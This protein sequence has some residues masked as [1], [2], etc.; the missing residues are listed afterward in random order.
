MKKSE[1]Q[2]STSK[3]SGEDDEA[4]KNERLKRLHQLR[5]RQVKEW[6]F[7]VHSS[8]WSFFL[9]FYL[10]F[11]LLRL[12]LLEWSSKAESSR[13]DRRGPEKEAARE[14]GETKGAPGARGREGAQEE[15]DRGA[16]TVV[17]APASSRVDGRRVR[18][19][20]EEEDEEAQS[21]YWLRRLRAGLA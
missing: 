14:L 18:A 15:G 8:S 13:S 2:P 11:F 20:G 1:Q 3:Q 7:F 9:C 10:I 19:M 6:I 21:R 4:K 16:G 5:M 17:R 12:N